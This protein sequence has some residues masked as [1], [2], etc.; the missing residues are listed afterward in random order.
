M[1]TEVTLFSLSQ[2]NSI[3]PSMDDCKCIIILVLFSLHYLQN[4]PSYPHFDS[5]LADGIELI[6]LA[7]I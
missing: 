5:D 2:I 6:N 4:L 3:R 7:V 1:N